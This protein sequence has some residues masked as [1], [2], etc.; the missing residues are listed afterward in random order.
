MSLGITLR[1]LSIN[2]VLYLHRVVV[3]RS[4]GAAVV[5]D[6]KLLDAAVSAPRASFGGVY[7]MKIFE[8]AS[9]YINSIVYNHPFLDGNKRTGLL[10]SLVFLH[11]NG[12]DINEEY[13]EQLAEK[14]LGL[15][16]HEYS[17]LDL[18]NFFQTKSYRV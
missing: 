14:V 13:E 10:S 3:V 12:Y 16:S 5:R 15:I 18:T 4:G 8:M 6:V 17:K 11:Y 9:T 7:L 1:F 2:A